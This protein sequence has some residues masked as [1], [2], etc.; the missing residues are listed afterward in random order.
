MSYNSKNVR[1]MAEILYCTNIAN[2]TEREC[3][4]SCES[5]QNLEGYEQKETTYVKDLSF[6]FI[7]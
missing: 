2:L 5:N 3:Q 4:K 7:H 6:K 1:T